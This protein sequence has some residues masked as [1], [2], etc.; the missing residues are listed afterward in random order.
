M[1]HFVGAVLLTASTAFAGQCDHLYPE[2]KPF[3]V[4][5]TIEL[6]NSFY[7]AIYDPKIGGVIAT[8]EVLRKGTPIG[9]IPRLSRFKA[10]PRLGVK[11]PKPSWYA[12]TGFDTGH[13]VPA[14]DAST[15]EEMADTFLMSNA[16]PQDPKLNRGAWRV[17]ENHA[18]KLVT[19]HSA[20]VTVV[21]IAEY[22]ETI[23][24]GNLPVPTGYWKIPHVEGKA[25][26][27]FAP[28]ELGGKVTVKEAVPLKVLLKR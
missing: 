15:P 4:P 6:C 11:G 7:V 3:N 26:Y 18:R 21:T 14:E 8:S 19:R 25:K 20:D 28:N 1:K 2:H 5:G 16:T 10:D 24:V 27:Y 17:V 9:S 23:R 22:K 13:M 12:G